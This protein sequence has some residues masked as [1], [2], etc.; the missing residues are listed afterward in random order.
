[1]AKSPL[2][3]PRSERVEDPLKLCRVAGK[4]LAAGHRHDAT[5]H[6]APPNKGLVDRRPLI[7]CQP[8]FRGLIRLGFLRL[9]VGDLA[10]DVVFVGSPATSVSFLEFLIRQFQRRARPAWMLLTGLR[11]DR[12]QI[13]K[14]I[15]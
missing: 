9:L 2:P 8:V 5:H 10:K 3:S 13:Q 7:D 12:R 4:W 6:R 11:G 1:M 15:E 14:L